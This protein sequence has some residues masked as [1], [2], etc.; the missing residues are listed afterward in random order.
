MKGA[1]FSTGTTCSLFDRSRHVSIRRGSFSFRRPSPRVRRPSPELRRP[2]PE[3]RRP[4]PELR[5]PIR[6]ETPRQPPG[7][8]RFET[9]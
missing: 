7:G 4:S 3:L 2:S 5:R 9:S 1:H 8:R 6:I